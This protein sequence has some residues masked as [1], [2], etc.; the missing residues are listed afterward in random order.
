MLIVR[1]PCEKWRVNWLYKAKRW[2][3][4]KQW[5]RLLSITNCAVR[6]PHN[7]FLHFKATYYSRKKCSRRAFFNSF[8]S[9]ISSFFSGTK[10]TGKVNLCIV[11]VESTQYSG[12]GNSK[13]QN[14]WFLLKK[15]AVKSR[16]FRILFRQNIQGICLDKV[17]ALL[18]LILGL[19]SK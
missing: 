18:A 6:R 14:L 8:G 17:F 15:Q 11:S 9:I 5:R 2:C 4:K 12:H 1:K 10:K 7:R 19:I 13:K 3:S 16:V